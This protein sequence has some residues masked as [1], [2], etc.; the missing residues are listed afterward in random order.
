MAIVTISRGT[1]S[2][3][4]AI[5]DRVSKELNYHC[6]TREE[7]LAKT[8]DQFK[9]PQEKLSVA[10]ASKPGFLEG[11][12]LRRIH[13]IAYIR[14]ALV[15]MVKEENVVYSGLAGH[16]LLHDA[17]NVLQVKVIADMEYRIKGAMERDNL[18]RDEAIKDIKKTTNDR[19]KWVKSIYHVDRNDP[20]GYD[21]VINLEHMT[22]PTACEVVCAV[23]RHQEFQPTPDT[24]KKMTDLIFASDIRA[25]IA[26]D[27]DIT[28]HD[29]EIDADGDTIHIWGTADSLD[30]ADRIREL[31]RHQ[32]GVKDIESHLR[33]QMQTRLHW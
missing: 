22:L 13:Y 32:P 9:I 21:L 33:A 8:A 16:L 31:V 11:H 20:R 5:A 24:Q 4:Q 23:A 17:P 12:K 26:L 10:M 7:L 25:K 19:N 28:D 29:I 2:G 27:R 14:A 15:R 18:S 6:I 30:D 3:G 1:Y